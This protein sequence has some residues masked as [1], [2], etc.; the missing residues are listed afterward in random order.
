MGELTFPDISKFKKLSIPRYQKLISHK[1]GRTILRGADIS[2]QANS[3]YTE[4]PEKTEKD[5]L[6]LLEVMKKLC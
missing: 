1:P 5:H 2:D 3:V 6:S 4:S